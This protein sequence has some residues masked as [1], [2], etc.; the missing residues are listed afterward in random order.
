MHV[1]VK[2]NNLTKDR[3]PALESP[4]RRIPAFDVTISALDKE[5]PYV[6][7]R[8]ATGKSQPGGFETAKV[9]TIRNALLMK[10]FAW[11]SPSLTQEGKT[12]L[13]D[14]IFNLYEY[15]RRVYSYDKMDLHFDSTKYGAVWAPSID[16]FFVVDGLKAYAKKLL[17]DTVHKAIELGSGSGFISKY[18]LSSARKLKELHAIDLDPDAVRCS[19]DNIRPLAEKKGVYDVE[20]RADG[21]EYIMKNG[22]QFDLV[23]SNPPYVPRHF[24]EEG[25]PYSGT[26]L[27]MGLVENCNSFLSSGGILLLNVSSLA[28]PERLT[29]IRKAEAGGLKC[30][31][32]SEMTVPFKVM[33]VQNDS[34]WMQFLQQ[35][36]GLQTQ[37]HDG[38]DYWHKLNLFAVKKR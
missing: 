24:T 19:A 16:T 34:Q 12:T 6:L 8:N 20:A 27:F 33:P 18:V 38:Y 11:V 36:R 31:Q 37:F 22:G 5:I 4:F 15:A 10:D 35:K 7:G 29:A 28:E 25:N 2:S 14:T 26:G 21:L 9:H 17:G 23:I 30:Y 3:V 13:R 1:E 32:I